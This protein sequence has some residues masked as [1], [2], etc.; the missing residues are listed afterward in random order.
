M[1]YAINRYKRLFPQYVLVLFSS[2]IVYVCVLQ[3]D[4]N[5][6]QIG[7]S[8]AKIFM[9]DGIYVHT[10]LNVM[11]QGWY[12]SVLWIDSILIYFLCARFGQKFTKKIASLL[13]IGIYVILF[14]KYGHLN[15]YTQFG[16]GITVGGFRGFAGLCL[17]CA[18]GN[19]GVR[20][21]KQSK[22]KEWIDVIVFLT[23]TGII[24]YALLWNMAYNKSDFVI[25]GFFLVILYYLLGDNNISRLFDR[26]KLSGLGNISYNMYLIHHVVAVLFGHFNWF[27]SFDW[28]IASLAYLGV[29][30]IC[31]LLF[32]KIISVIKSGIYNGKK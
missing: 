22:N 9:L 26:H 7:G 23:G 19:L 28:K 10:Q 3:F 16:F 27:R 14:W 25:L 29:V 1:E 11:P 18:L 17:G 2:I 5:I 13:A 30:I 8:V 32:E 15:L 31:S 20:E 6:S 24:F 12:C 4:I 21:R